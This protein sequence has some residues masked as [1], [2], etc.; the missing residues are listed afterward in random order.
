MRGAMKTQKE[1]R[2]PITTGIERI[3]QEQKEWRDSVPGCNQQFVFL[4]LRNP[5]LPF[6]N[7]FSC[8]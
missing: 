3:L 4:Q 5:E 8:S 2:I 1:F 7:G 6:A